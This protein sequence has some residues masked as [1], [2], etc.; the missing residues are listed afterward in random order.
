MRAIL[1]DHKRCRKEWNELVIRGCLARTRAAL[2]IWVEVE[3]VLSQAPCFCAPILE[4]QARDGG[5][6]G[7]E[8]TSSGLALF[9]GASA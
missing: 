4:P 9:F 1:L 6:G 7:S 8:L 3:C 5:R 2:E